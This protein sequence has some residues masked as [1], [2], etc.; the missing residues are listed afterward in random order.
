MVDEKKAFGKPV[1]KKT[2]KLAPLREGVK[3]NRKGLNNFI[4]GARDIG[5]T[6]LNV[7]ERVPV[8]PPP[9]KKKP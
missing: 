2:G 7:S 4:D 9:K 5:R 1:T 3:I 8:P 6:P